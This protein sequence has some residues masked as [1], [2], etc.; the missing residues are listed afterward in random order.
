MSI[1]HVTHPNSNPLSLAMALLLLNWR[2]YPG[3]RVAFYPGL[4]PGL[5]PL[6]PANLQNTCFITVPVPG[7]YAG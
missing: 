1:Q 2:H 6:V 5:P 3:P 4:P 7:E